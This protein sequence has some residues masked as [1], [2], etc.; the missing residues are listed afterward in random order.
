MPGGMPA[1]DDGEEKDAAMPGEEMPKEP[2]A[3]EG[4]GV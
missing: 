1:D 2:S 4:E 3:D